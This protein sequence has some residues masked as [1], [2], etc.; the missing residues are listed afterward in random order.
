MSTI[1]QRYQHTHQEDTPL[2]IKLYLKREG[3][4]VAGVKVMQNVVQADFAAPG[5]ITA[6]AYWDD[7]TVIV[8]PFALSVPAVIYDTPLTGSAGPALSWNFDY[9]A[10]ASFF[11]SATT[12]RDYLT[13]L[14]F[15]LSDGV[16]WKVIQ[17]H[18]SLLPTAGS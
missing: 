7:E 15:T 2:A 4:V 11:P 12:T 3:L 6:A 16:L 10:P 17:I 5:G 8:A 14:R 18:G 9:I 13:E 1:T